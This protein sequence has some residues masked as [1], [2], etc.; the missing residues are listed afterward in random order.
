MLKQQTVRWEQALK[1]IKID[2][3]MNAASRPWENDES[4]RERPAH[5]D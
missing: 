4:G 3:G 2:K 1:K 5:A